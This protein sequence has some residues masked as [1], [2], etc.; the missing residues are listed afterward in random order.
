VLFVDDEQILREVVG[1]TLQRSGYR[2]VTASD[3]IEALA[4]FAERSKEISVTVIDL[5][6]PNLD[7]P[8]TIKAM[9]KLNPDARLV[10]I[11]GH[12]EAMR[13]AGATLSPMVPLLGKPFTSDELLSTIYEQIHR[14]Q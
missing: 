2:V 6:M 14:E 5:L 13:Q 10:A 7:G 4:R 1:T 3:G 11:S 9:R 8:I 12:E